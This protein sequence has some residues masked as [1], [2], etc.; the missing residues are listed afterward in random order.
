MQLTSS[1]L[2]TL[3]ADI[4]ADPVLSVLPLNPDSA[5]EIANAYNL[6][7]APAYLVWSTQVTRDEIMTDPAWAWD[8]VDNLTVGKARIWD[9][10]FNTGFIDPSK[11]NIRTGIAAAWTGTSADLAQRDVVMAHCK[12]NATRAEKLYSIATPGGV[13]T[14]GSSANPDTMVFV[15]PLDPRD[16]EKARELP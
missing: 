7:A 12:R 4:A 16:V 8:R 5:V 1:Q 6:A 3:K 10:M 14:R 13:G 2:Q 15:G 11:A 9:W